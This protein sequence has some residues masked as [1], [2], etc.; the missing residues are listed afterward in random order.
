MLQIL[1]AEKPEAA[2]GPGSGL[3]QPLFLIKANGIH[4]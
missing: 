3:K 2:F 4:R 1:P